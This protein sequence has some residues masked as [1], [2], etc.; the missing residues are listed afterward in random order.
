MLASVTE[1][2]A[3]LY[4]GAESNPGDRVLG[5]IEKD[6]FIVQYSARQRETHWASASKNYVSQ[7]QRI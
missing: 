1:S 4:T 6:G 7:P 2:S 5:E 3:S